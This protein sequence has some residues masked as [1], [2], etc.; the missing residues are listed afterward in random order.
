MF[1]F[2]TKQTPLQ[3]NISVFAIIVASFCFVGYLLSSSYFS[4]VHLQKL[5]FTQAH[6]SLT[7]KAKS[8]NSFFNERQNDLRRLATGEVINSYFINKDMNMSLEYGLKASQVFISKQFKLLDKTV[9]INEKSI[10]ERLTLFDSNGEIIV[11]F[12][13]KEHDFLKNNLAK[14]ISVTTSASIM[15]DNYNHGYIMIVAP[16]NRLN[17][18]VGWVVGWIKLENIHQH[19]SHSNQFLMVL[20]RPAYHVLELFMVRL[21]VTFLVATY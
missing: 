18:I 16:V 9:L 19:L 8:L 4:Q 7:G 11:D 21:V 15:H 20:L 6:N 5:A 1:S 10:Y 14:I 12:Q 3:H 13:D 2:N 17:K